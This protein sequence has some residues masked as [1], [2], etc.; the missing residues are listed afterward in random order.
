MGALGGGYGYC[1]VA[2]A[3]GA[4][5]DPAALGQ[6]Y[7]MSYGGYHPRY[8]GSVGQTNRHGEPRSNT[9]HDAGTGWASGNEPQVKATGTF[10][11]QTGF[12]ATGPGLRG[13]PQGY[14]PASGGY[15]QMV[16]GTPG[17][18]GQGAYGSAVNHYYPGQGDQPYYAD[19][20]DVEDD[21][22]AE[23]VEGDDEES[24]HV[25]GQSPVQVRPDQV[26]PVL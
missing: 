11:S 18:A 24:A 13:S 10:T 1:H 16:M 22:Y 3:S 9:Y 2:G 8:E 17:A 14:S 25:Q 4:S 6:S 23:Y 7:G 20:Y 19:R 26:R 12:S 15:S 21:E 5:Y